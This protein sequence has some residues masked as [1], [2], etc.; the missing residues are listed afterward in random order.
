LDQKTDSRRVI[1]DKNIFRE[2]C[3]VNRATGN[4][5]ETTVGS[6]CLFMTQSHVGHNCHIGNEVILSNIAT[7]AGHVDVHD[8]AIM[9]GLVAIPQFTRI[10]KGAFLGG[11]SAIRLD[12]PPFFRYSGRPAE[13]VGVNHVGMSRR[14]ISRESIRA[15]RK[16]YRILYR[17]NLSLDDAMSRIEEEYGQFEEVGTI[18]DFVSSA[19]NGIARPTHVK[20]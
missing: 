13:P 18:L 5:A 8:W 11:F 20:V 1:G 10:G 17:S 14:G 12:L 15:V 3:S 16:V 7:L 19:P 9:G 6:E 4:G 2:Y